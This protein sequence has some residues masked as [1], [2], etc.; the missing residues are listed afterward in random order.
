[1]FKYLNRRIVALTLLIVVLALLI[2][3]RTTELFT[4]QGGSEDVDL[5]LPPY[6]DGTVTRRSYEDLPDID[7]D[8][9]EY[10]LVNQAHNCGVYAPD[11]V[12]IEGTSSYF[13]L[14]AIDKLYALLDAARAAGF[15]PHVYVGYRA[16]V[17]QADQYREVVASLVE[18]GYSQADAEREA[19]ETSSEP[20]T[21]EHQTGLCLD[22]LDRYTESLTDFQMDPAFEAWLN[23]HVVEYGFIMRYPEDKISVTGRYEPWHIRYVGEEAAQFMTAHNLAL[24]EF[25]T[26][27][28]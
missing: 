18:K 17:I 25:V 27:Y 12:Q 8:S 19:A 22:L 5:I 15:D 28:H 24:E 7:I 16:Y 6:V 14:R 13:D 20:G 21:S 2:F 23:E 11:V 10:M 9:W 26:L 1:M 3:S 4:R